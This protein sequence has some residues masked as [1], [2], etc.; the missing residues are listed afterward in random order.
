MHEFLISIKLALNN[1]RSNKARTILSMTGIVIG[2]LSVILVL[3][4]GMGIKGYIVGQVESFGTDIIQIE[5][6]VPDVS[7]YSSQNVRGA[8]SGA[9]TTFKLDDAEMVGKVKNISGWYAANIGQAIASHSSSTK[10][11]MIFAATSGNFQIDQQAKIAEGRAY[12]EEEDK[13]LDQVIV[14]GS[15]VKSALFGQEDTLEKNVK[16]KG[17]NYR[18]VGVLHERGATGFFNF[19][20]LVYIPLRTYQKKIAGIDYIQS[21]VFKLK[22]KKLTDATIAEAEDV[23][24]RQHD[25]AN[26]DKDDF[27]VNSIS[28]ITGIL[29]KVFLIVN[30]LLISLTSISL[31]VGGVGI[32]NVMYVSVTE[33]TAEIG[34]RKAVGAKNSSI[35]KQFLFEAVFVTMLGGIAGVIFGWI[36]T[37]LA[38]KAAINAGYT[39]SFGISWLG[40]LLAV[41]FSIAIGLGFGLYPARKASQLSPMEALRKE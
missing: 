29:D 13:S 11:V 36:V 25:I 32:M 19:D 37:Y 4:L 18:V 33:R 21:T 40:V 2:V 1:L 28:E 17:A 5:P 20:D 39:V 3:S 8:T 27:A 6:K 35:L 10:Q 16:I 30:I 34:L 9:I 14:L 7:K 12:T 26:P 23:M 38:T 15:N 22:D 31:I 41:G 24:R